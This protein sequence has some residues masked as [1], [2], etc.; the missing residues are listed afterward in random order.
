MSPVGAAEPSHRLELRARRVLTAAELARA[1]QGVHRAAYLLAH[2]I[3]RSVLGEQLCVDPA[4]VALAAAPCE[5]CGGPHGK[6]VLAGSDEL[7]LSLSHT[8]G[9]AVVALSSEPVGVDA[10]PAGGRSWRSAQLS[11]V[12][13]PRELAE[14]ARV[15]IPHRD[16]AIL[17]CWV[18]KEAYLKGR[19]SGLNRALGSCYVG[20]PGSRGHPNPDWAVADVPLST[21]H[22]C[23]TAARS[24]T[25]AT[26]SVE[27]RAGPRFDPH[28][29]AIALPQR[30]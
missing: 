15:A 30:C 1:P 18:R 5:R 28:T 16:R 7:H 8:R 25:P 29:G 22:V 17:G 14:L 11:E 12:L 20:L 19:G 4:R 23:A 6:P 2:L 26:L 10:E 21:G 27:V 24:T 13:H 9:L 3:L